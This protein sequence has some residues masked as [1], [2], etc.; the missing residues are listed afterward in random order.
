MN[1]IENYKKDFLFLLNKC[2]LLFKYIDIN[3]QHEILNEIKLYIQKLNTI[4]SIYKDK[5]KIFQILIEYFNILID[6]KIYKL[7]EHPDKNSIIESIDKQSKLLI[8]DSYIQTQQTQ[9]KSQII[10]T[11]YIQEEELNNFK[12]EYLYHLEKNNIKFEN[13]INIKLEEICNEIKNN[14]KIS[15]TEYLINT[16]KE[17]ID[18]KL[19][20]EKIKLTIKI[21]RTNPIQNESA[22]R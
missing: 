15:L 4:S 20:D 18:P 5:I 17:N 16:K 2:I 22:I 12:E 14:L 10:E 11:Q 7:I 19:I 3:V 9:Q 21:P 6:T 13:K 8:Y 1:N